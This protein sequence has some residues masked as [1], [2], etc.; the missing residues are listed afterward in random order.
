MG[1]I[2][3]NIVAL[4]LEGDLTEW[5]NQHLQQWLYIKFRHFHESAKNHA[6]K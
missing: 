2:I 5:A 3:S 1:L 6:R 4:S